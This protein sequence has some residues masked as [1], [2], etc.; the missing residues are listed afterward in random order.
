MKRKKRN[1]LTGET[2]LRMKREADA[3]APVASMTYA[4]SRDGVV[5]S[6][7]R[8]DGKGES[9][10]G[11]MAYDVQEHPDGT[12]HDGLAFYVKVSLFNVEG[13]DGILHRAKH[14]Q[15]TVA[16]TDER[17]RCVQVLKEIKDYFKWKDD[18]SVIRAGLSRL[19]SDVERMP[20]RER[21]YSAPELSKR[22]LASIL[23]GLRLLQG[24]GVS[25]EDVDMIDMI[26]NGA[27]EFPPLSDE[28][29]DVLCE[30]LNYCD[31]DKS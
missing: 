26:A 8:A 18:G 25:S 9:F 27:G 5:V 13:P 14:W 20:V 28:D 1:N 16:F 12:V 29:I 2:A 10:F 22:E 21:D 6:I 4:S 23:A 24:N 17:T 31:E 30:R 19:A 11:H 3:K 15:W 7:K